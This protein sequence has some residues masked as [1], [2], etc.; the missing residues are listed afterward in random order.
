[1]SRATQDHHLKN[2]VGPESLLLYTKFEGNR[3][4]PADFGEKK[5]S[6]KGLLPYM[7]MAAILVTG[8]G[9]TEQ[10]FIL[11]THNSSTWNYTSVGLAALQQKTFE[12]IKLRDIE[13]RSNNDLDRWDSNV[14]LYSFRKLY[15]QTFSL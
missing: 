15:V 1:M 4:R 13:H 9:P 14:F 6:V 3:P 7:D 8:P 11:P 12:S 10:T 5:K 2:I